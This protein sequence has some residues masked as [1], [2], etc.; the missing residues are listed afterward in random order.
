MRA[1]QADRR[2]RRVT[3]PECLEHIG[4]SPDE[5]RRLDPPVGGMF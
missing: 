2:Q 1:D 5:T 3:A 4:E